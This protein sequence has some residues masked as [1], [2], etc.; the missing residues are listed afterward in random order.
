M[1]AAINGN[2]IYSSMIFSKFC[3]ET[4]SNCCRGIID[5]AFEESLMCHSIG[6]VYTSG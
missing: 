4:N 1:S 3:A 2:A 6:D 5:E